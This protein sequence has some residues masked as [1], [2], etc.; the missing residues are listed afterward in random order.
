V[1]KCSEQL[2]T[3]TFLGSDPPP[4]SL[5][6]FS[7]RYLGNS[8]NLVA[9]VK[10]VVGVCVCFSVGVCLVS[11]VCFKG[12]LLR[13]LLMFCCQICHSQLVVWEKLSEDIYECFHTCF[14]DPIESPLLKDQWVWQRAG[15]H[16]M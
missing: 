5:V 8:V 14:F 1:I 2:H 10:L 12:E 4:S 13:G 7:P 3:L 11:S 16:T 6:F 9:G 15:G